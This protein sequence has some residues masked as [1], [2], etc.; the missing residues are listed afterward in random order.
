[1]AQA[2]SPSVIG[3][4]PQ[5]GNYLGIVTTEVTRENMG[6]YSMREP[7][8]VVITR[9][10]EDSPAS[11]AGLKAGDVILRFD[12]E[13]VTTHNKLQ[14]LISEAA[15]EQ[16]VRLGISRNGSEQEVS[17]TV[18]RR[19]NSF[20]NIFE[21]YPSQGT[22]EAR[23]ALDQM[24]Q[25]QG[26]MS[27]FAGRRIGI[28]TTPLTKQLAEYFG[29]TAGHGLLITSVVENSPAA[30]AGLKAGDVIIDADGE[31]VE[32]SGDLSRAINRKN[33]GTV[34]LKIV[35][36]RNSMSVTVTPEKRETGALTISP[37][38][39]EIEMGELEIKLPTLI[40]F[41]LIKPIRIQ[42]VKFP[43]VK[44]SPKQ[45]EMLRKLEGMTLEDLTL[46]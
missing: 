43:K 39:L 46:L 22:E 20:Q 18:G 23:R 41:P 21:A 5:S 42:P 31:K 25:N 4:A 11:R 12:N 44:I 7:R 38:L 37:E 40:Q 8:G 17:V 10:A 29:V 34:T 9:V 24:R 13:P 1:V 19:K 28:N 27:F 33:E 16:T 26:T 32:S 45:L 2:D 30:R 14:R 15:P 3:F 6:R 35:R 36:D